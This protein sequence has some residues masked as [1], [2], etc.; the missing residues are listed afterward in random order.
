MAVL[1]SPINAS[2]SIQMYERLE[3]ESKSD[4][5]RNYDTLKNA[6]IVENSREKSAHSKIKKHNKR[7][8]E[9]SVPYERLNSK[10][11]QCQNVYDTLQNK[12]KGEYFAQ[13]NSMSKACGK[14][15]QTDKKFEETP[16]YETLNSARD[17]NKSYDILKKSQS[18]DYSRTQ[19]VERKERR[20]A[21]LI[22]EINSTFHAS[23]KSEHSY[24]SPLHDMDNI[25][26]EQERSYAY[27]SFP[28]NSQNKKD[29]NGK[30][31]KHQ[32]RKHIASFLI[33][34]IFGGVVFG[35]IVFAVLKIQNQDADNGN[36]I[37]PGNGTSNESSCVWTV[38]TQ[39]SD[40]SVLCGNGT[41]HRNRQ[42]NG[43]T[44]GCLPRTENQTKSCNLGGIGCQGTVNKSSCVLTAWTQWSDCSVLC[45]NGTQH[46]NR[47]HN[48]GTEGCLP[49]TENQTKSC[50]L[51][52]IEC[53]APAIDM[54]FD[55]ATLNSECFLSIDNRI[56]SNRHHSSQTPKRSS[57]GDKSLK[58]YSGVIANRCF[59]VK[60][61]VWFKVAY[62]YTIERL[63]S[64]TNLILEVGL[65][66]RNEIDNHYFVGNVQTKGWSFALAR[67]GEDNDDVC[68]RSKHREN[69]LDNIFFSRNI[70]GLHKNGTFDL[71]LD[72]QNNTFQLQDL[73]AT[74]SNISFEN[75]V[76]VNELCPVFG[77]YGSNM[78]D[79]QIQILDSKDLT[80]S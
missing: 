62:T 75:V 33:G 42:H 68:L 27:A 44:E 8:T 40:C 64:F 53:Q 18:G 54:H 23:Q 36:C 73:S 35:I 41:Q 38:W 57:E 66:D 49:R 11:S 32:T 56:L 48:G 29:K 52:G 50:N 78:L 72:R 43:G 24:C 51:G 4:Y 13:Q 1:G 34:F 10:H 30:T 71:V 79:V 22:L 31:V 59:G 2:N 74:H 65:A 37:F 67:C 58:K 17:Q 69:L 63:L 14:I 20:Q 28:S 5:G 15:A 3:E 61:K 9:E 77:V 19:S 21:E 70:I 76:S 6:Q 25:D 39:W 45:G 16:G 7:E 55:P 12:Q 47:Q 26:L 80:N 46:R 60:K